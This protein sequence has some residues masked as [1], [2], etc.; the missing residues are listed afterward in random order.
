M[1]E[2]FEQT[3]KRRFDNLQEESLV[4]FGTPASRDPE[5]NIVNG[6]LIVPGWV[7][8]ISLSRRI[9]TH[10]TTGMKWLGSSILL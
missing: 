3:T 10:G 8:S 6:S 5:Y 4:R 1:I 2:E 7:L 9:G